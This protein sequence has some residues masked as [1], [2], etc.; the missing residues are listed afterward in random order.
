MAASVSPEFLAAGGNRHP[1]AA[2]WDASGSGLL[3]FG[4]DKNVA[5][6]DPLDETDAGISDLLPGHVETVTAV[7]F[8]AQ[9]EQP[10]RPLLLSGSADGEI[11]LWAYDD[12]V[13]EDKYQT[14]T[15]LREHRK[16]INAIAVLPRLD[17]FVSGAADAEVRV[18]QVH[19]PQ[20]VRRR[21]TIVLQPK[22]FPLAISLQTL[23]PTG[24]SAI[25]AVAGTRTFIQLYSTSHRE[26]EFDHVATLTGH[27]GWIRSLSFVA[28]SNASDGDLLLASTSQDKYI[29]LW[30]ISVSTPTSN[31]PSQDVSTTSS[32]AET[33]LSNKVHRFT[34]AHGTSHTAT[35]EAL[36]LGHEDWIFTCRWHH[37]P[38]SLTLL[39]ASADN[40]LAIWALDAASGV[41][42]C[43]VRLGEINAQKGATT[44][45]GSA[46]GFWTGL[47]APCGSAVVSLGRTG[48]W[49]RWC[50][51]GSDPT[52]RWRQRPAVTGHARAVHDLAWAPD[53]AYL[54]STGADQTTRLWAQRASG[55]SAP[56]WHEFSRPQ[57]HGYDIHCLASVG[58]ARFVSGADEKL[59]RVFDEPRAVAETLAALCSGAAATEEDATATKRPDTASIP[60][61]GLSNK[62]VE[63]EPVDTDGEP[64]DMVDAPTGPPTEDTLSRNLLWPESEKLY[65]HGYEIS[66]VAATQPVSSADSSFSTDTDA[67]HGLLATACRA[68]SL[69]HAVIR[70]YSTTT[71]R[72]LTPPLAFHTL[73]ATRLAFS[74]CNTHLLSVGRDRACAVFSRPTA[75]AAAPP[76][77]TTTTTITTTTEHGL[78][79]LAS[80]QKAHARMIL[81]AAWL[82]SACAAGAP[83]FVT[84]GRDKQLHVWTA[85]AGDGAH[86][87]VRAASIA[88]SAPV[89]A[90]AA[91]ARV[92][93]DGAVALA[94]G[95][96]DGGVVVLVLDAQTLQ[97]RGAPLALSARE[98]PAGAVS[99]MAWRP[100]RGLESA[101]EAA[102]LAV[103][104]EDGSV[105]VYRVEFGA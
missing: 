34:D 45:T 55:S 95:R 38:N 28:E 69:D 17:I 73:T 21:Q 62:A 15:V 25:L 30:R 26:G 44:A 85:R 52:G 51:D 41:W 75:A 11:R 31:G 72:A 96:E 43:T 47:W 64:A 82:P 58:A 91:R 97:V 22:F 61:L 105:R 39:T 53:G 76:S 50:R 94:Y 59:L 83:A 19:S 40:S 63:V 33:S 88:A 10:R 5:L 81:D 54:L 89:T 16:A 8:Y 3:A 84:A 13:A 20:D 37:H 80:V 102:R 36:L 99:R 77:V 2:D 104:G 49:R 87:L 42:S 92:H 9:A 101:A 70:L 6:W 24:E 67:A 86:Q 78:V 1:S 14:A 100:G 7:Y 71:W 98:A 93:A 35:F 29:R 103:A 90:V 66:A 79:L 74:P 68:S 56:S 23:S 60:V 32:R 57:I 65:G 27:D 46:G 12:D 48:G 18:W 4:S